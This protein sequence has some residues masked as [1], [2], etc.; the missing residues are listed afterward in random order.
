MCADAPDLPYARAL[1]YDGAM[2][3]EELA[4][5]YE[6]ARSMPENAVVVEIGS[7]KGR[8][9]VATCEGLSS[10]PG[11]RF[12]AIDPWRRKDVRT[13]DVYEA[14]DP[15]EDRVY[16]R[17]LR[18]TGPYDFVEPMRT[19]SLEAVKDFA[20]ESVDWIFIDGDHRFDAIRADILAWY[21]KVKPGGLVSGHDYSWFDVRSAVKGHLDP[22]AVRDSIWHVRKSSPSVRNR[23]LPLWAGAARRDLRRAPMLE[24]LVRAFVRAIRR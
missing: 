8:S 1:R 12:V 6:T 15:D 22:V 19:T 20:D 21:P 4:F 5:L 13:G 23:P 24:R 10:V 3:P 18:N 14:G 11:A 9:S 7:F 16:R 2:S 17:F